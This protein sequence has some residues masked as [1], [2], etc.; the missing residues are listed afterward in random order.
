MRLKRRG[1][2]IAFNILFMKPGT[3]T[4]EKYWYASQSCS[5][6]A[7]RIQAE[8]ERSVELLRLLSH[9]LERGHWKVAVR[10]FQM[11]LEFDCDIPDSERAA[12]EALISQLSPRERS[13]IVQDVKAW[14]VFVRTGMRRHAC[15]D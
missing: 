8:R 15:I 7:S 1:A 10:R 11:L 3:Q 9:S 6:L 13:K 2:C 4:L 5:P 14:A 12:C